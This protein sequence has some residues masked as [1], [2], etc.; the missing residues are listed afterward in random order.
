VNKHEIAELDQKLAAPSQTAVQKV[1]QALPEETV[2]MAW[3]SSLNEELLSVAKARR[4]SDVIRTWLMRPL[5]GLALAGA[6]SAVVFLRTPHRAP[7]ATTKAPAVEAALIAAHEEA[8][9][10]GEV[11]GTGLSPVEVAYD[12]SRPVTDIEWSELDVESL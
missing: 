2:S 5:A 1:I 6:L 8:A 12:T 7:V 4:K 3:R 11:T 9:S 10:Y